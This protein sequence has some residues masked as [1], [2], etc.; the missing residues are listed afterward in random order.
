[1][2]G[3]GAMCYGIIE[4]GYL[5]QKGNTMYNFAKYHNFERVDHSKI[6][7]EL[8]PRFCSSILKYKLVNL[9]LIF[10]KVTSS[11]SISLPL[12]M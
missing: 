9:V 11:Y 6:T 10:V 12:K 5:T 8:S 3:W 4:K 1:M 7:W 2:C